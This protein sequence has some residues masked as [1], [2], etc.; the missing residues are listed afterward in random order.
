MTEIYIKVGVIIL[1][2]NNEIL[3]LKE[4]VEQDQEPAWNII[5]GTFESSSERIEECAKRECLE[6]VGLEVEILGIHNIIFF[7]KTDNKLKIQYNFVARAKND[8][9]SLPKERNAQIEGED[10]QELKWIKMDEID[11]LK[12]EDFV[13]DY[14]LS[15]LKSWIKTKNIYPADMFEYIA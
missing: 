6:E 9:A 11:G 2:D 13:A 12:S 1:N 10:I 7:P 14:T 15:I 4:K 3:L 5:K 8:S